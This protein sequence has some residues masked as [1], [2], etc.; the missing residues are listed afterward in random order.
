[1]KL[2]IGVIGTGIMG[3]HH[4]KTV[5]TARSGMGKITPVDSRAGQTS[6]INAT[7]KMLIPVNPIFDIPRQRAATMAK[8]STDECQNRIR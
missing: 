2:G 8:I 3:A 1:M 7:P 4:T 6:A 5:T